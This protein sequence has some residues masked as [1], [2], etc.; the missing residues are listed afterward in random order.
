[1]FEYVILAVVPFYRGAKERIECGVFRK[2]GHGTDS[3]AIAYC[4]SRNDA[5][6]VARALNYYQKD[7]LR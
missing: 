3:E 1:M 7:S 2:M 4:S 5:E 6:I